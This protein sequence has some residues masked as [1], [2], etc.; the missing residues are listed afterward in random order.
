MSVSGC[1]GVS[2][3]KKWRS[4]VLAVYHPSAYYTPTPFHAELTKWASRPRIWWRGLGEWVGR[5]AGS[6]VALL[7]SPPFWA[8]TR[9]SMFRSD[10][11]HWPF[12]ETACFGVQR[13]TRVS[14]S[15][16]VRWI[17]KYVR[18]V[19]RIKRRIRLRKSGF[20]LKSK[21]RRF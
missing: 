7:K 4:R 21:T 20:E 1:E 3:P 2:D 13:E 18:V 8:S 16:P 17:S 6:K 14:Q 10:P 12:S 11:A 15:D 5:R 19:G 9:N